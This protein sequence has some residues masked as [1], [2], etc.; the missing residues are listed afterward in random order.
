MVLALFSFL[1]WR[2]AF[3]L[4]HTDGLHAA[5][6]N[7]QF[8]ELTVTRGPFRLLLPTALFLQSSSGPRHAIYSDSCAFCS[9]SMVLGIT[10][11]SRIEEMALNYG[12]LG[13]WAEEAAQ[14]Q[15]LPPVS[16]SGGG[17]EPRGWGECSSAFSSLGTNFQWHFLWLRSLLLGL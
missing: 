7:L 1:S 12:A 10:V 16:K 3:F 17:R 11:L 8:L 9:G 6:R 15:I 4:T 5:C 13:A 2:D 14:A